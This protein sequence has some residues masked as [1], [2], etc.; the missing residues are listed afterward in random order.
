MVS[1]IVRDKGRRRDFAAT[2]KLATSVTD[3]AAGEMA[4]PA[5]GGLKQSGASTG[6]WG[7]CRG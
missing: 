6:Q 7:N 4:P 1:S 2:A 3:D 5:S